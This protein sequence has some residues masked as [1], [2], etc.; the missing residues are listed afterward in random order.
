MRQFSRSRGLAAGGA[1]VLGAALLAGEASAQ[2]GGAAD[3]NGFYVGAEAGWAFSA[4]DD[5]WRFTNAN[6]FNTLGATIVG[7]D[8]GFSPDGF[9]GGG[10]AGYNRQS[11]N[12]V[13]GA[14]V[15]IDGT[16]YE[17]KKPSP[18]FPAIDTFK[19]EVDWIAT[20]AG[21]LGYS[22]GRWLAYA[23]AGYAGGDVE[24][25]LVD[26]PSAIIATLDGWANGYVAGAG[27]EYALTDRIVF[28]VGYSHVGLFIDDRGM[29]CG[30]CGVGVGFGTPDVS[31]DINIDKVAARLTVRLR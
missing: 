15:G 6:Y 20:V 28:G 19:T 12:W 3:W 13:F 23:K 21:R 25:R 14:E 24:L 29:S 18:F 9:I 10:L 11:G 31:G 5:D 30:T 17:D 26:T 8:F 16:L 4:F 2:S 7:N 27:L 22:A 1:F